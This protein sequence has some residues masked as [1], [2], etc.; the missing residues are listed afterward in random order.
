MY[1]FS[2]SHLNNVTLPDAHDKSLNVDGRKKLW[3]E[4]RSTDECFI[5]IPA[6]TLPGENTTFVCFENSLSDAIR[7]LHIKNFHSFLKVF[8][9]T[10]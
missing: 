9:W 5:Y 6:G 4:C 10:K 7:N 3:M 8:S 1:I 2:R